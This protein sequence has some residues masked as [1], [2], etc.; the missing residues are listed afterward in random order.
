MGLNSRTKSISAQVCAQAKS[1]KRLQRDLTSQLQVTSGHTA[2]LQCGKIMV[3]VQVRSI[4]MLQRRLHP[5]QVE[6]RSYAACRGKDLSC[7]TTRSTGCT[8]KSSGMLPI[9]DQSV[10]AII[11]E[12]LQV[13]VRTGT[14]P[15]GGQLSALWHSLFFHEY[16]RRVGMVPRSSLKEGKN[17]QMV[18]KGTKAPKPTQ[19]QK[20]K[21]AGR[22]STIL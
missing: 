3:T 1:Q 7:G 11:D 2:T 15:K 20:P 8:Y 18:E 19:N 9:G 4:A 16:G 17:R 10:A 21:P 13:M 6:W 22:N 5:W 12:S 14:P